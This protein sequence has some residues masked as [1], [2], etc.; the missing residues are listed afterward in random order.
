MDFYDRNKVVVFAGTKWKKAGTKFQNENLKIQENVLERNL[1][2]VL[3]KSL[4][5]KIYTQIFNYFFF[6]YF[7]AMFKRYCDL[8]R[9]RYET[10]W[11][12]A[13]SFHPK[14]ILAAYLRILQPLLMIQPRLQVI[15]DSPVT[16]VII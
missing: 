8:P 1:A 3:L 10:L 13:I 6:F 4:V 14:V 9:S 7:I 12:Q 5:F 16:A 2:R 15:L 11:T